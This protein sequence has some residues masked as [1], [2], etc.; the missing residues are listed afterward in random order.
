M[1]LDITAYS[2]IENRGIPENDFDIS[3]IVDSADDSFIFYNTGSNSFSVEY[4]L[5]DGGVRYG[6][7]KC[8]D[9]KPGLYYEGYKTISHSFRA[10]SYGSYN[11]FRKN[12]CL[13]VNGVYPAEIWETPDKWRDSPLFDLINFSDCEG[14]IGPEVSRKLYGEMNENYIKFVKFIVDQYSEHGNFHI[15][16][17][18]KETYEDFMK[19][20]EIASEDGIVIFA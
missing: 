18:H 7:D 8:D 5:P 19:C 16:E 12:I 4:K 13:S 2:N 15:M 1:G 10:G 9:L 20:F 3:E 11:D 14:R 17:Y 6:Y